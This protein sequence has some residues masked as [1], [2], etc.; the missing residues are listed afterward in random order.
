MLSSQEGEHPREISD[1]T[2]GS[3]K[4]GLTIAQRF[5][6]GELGIISDVP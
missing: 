4:E 3:Q 2:Q 1:L 5:S 6:A